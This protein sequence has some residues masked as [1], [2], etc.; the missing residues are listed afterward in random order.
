MS[1]NKIQHVNIGENKYDIDLPNDAE[2]SIKRLEVSTE[3][4]TSVVAPNALYL[5]DSNETHSIQLKAGGEGQLQISDANAGVVDSYTFRING[6]ENNIVATL[7]DISDTTLKNI[8]DTNGVASALEQ[9]GDSQYGT[10]FENTK[11]GR[12]ALSAAATGVCS[13]M[14]GGKSLSSGKRS[15]TNGTQC[16]AQGNYSHAEGNNTY[17]EGGSSHAEGLETG[18]Y[19]NF[20]HSEGNNT[21]AK[22]DQSHSEGNHT[23]AAG[24]NSHAEGQQTTASGLNAHSEGYLTAANG[25]GSHVEG[26]STK[27]QTTKYS[28]PSPGG[29]GSGIDPTPSESGWNIE[30]QRGKFSHAEGVNTIASG[31]TSHAEGAGAVAD[32]H[33][34]HAEGES[35]LATGRGAHA[36]G[37]GS[38]ASGDFSHAEGKGN[39]TSGIASF[40][41]GNENIVSGDY[42]VAFGNNNTV[43]GSSSIA[44]GVGLTSGAGV[45]GNAVFGRYNEVTDGSILQVGAGSSNVSRTVFEVLED[46]RAKV[47]GAPKDSTDVVRLT[48]L[49]K[50]TTE[51]NVKALILDETTRML[52]HYTGING[53]ARI[54]IAAMDLTH[55]V[56]SKPDPSTSKVVYTY[57]N[58]LEAVNNTVSFILYYYKDGARWTA[59]FSSVTDLVDFLDEKIPGYVSTQEITYKGVT[60]KLDLSATQEENYLTLVGGRCVIEDFI[61]DFVPTHDGNVLK[62][63]E[64]YNN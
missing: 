55:G 24:E 57:S 59:S 26:Y 27:S 60:F 41:S 50:Y 54:A 25:E 30:E 28:T 43:G 17:T 21:D 47:D 52:K 3:G 48:D 58:V 12:V 44:V 62:I 14:L 11:T 38:I 13:T 33:I 23:T 6:K 64:F 2:I 29:S 32:G 56:T 34:S 37:A 36:E 46:G 63:V 8:R 5:A 19:G 1:N 18:A 10:A 31:W 40:A 45:A 35:T 39:Q 61:A 53:Y 16:I 49:S 22:G 7:D 51:G 20:S 42:S 15:L 9:K 4:A